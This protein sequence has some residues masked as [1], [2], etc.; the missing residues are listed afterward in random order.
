MV[1]AGV[2]TN[3]SQFV[4]TTKAMPHLNGRHVAFGK[5]IE[6]MEV[7]NEMTKIFSVKGKPLAEVKVVDCGRL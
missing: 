5:V 3:A 1:S 2:D 7:I 6:G 4:V